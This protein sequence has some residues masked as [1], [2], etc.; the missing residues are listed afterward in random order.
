MIKSVVMWLHILVVSLLMCVYRTVGSCFCCS[1][2]MELLDIYLNCLKAK[3]IKEARRR[4]RKREE[5][6]ERN[7]KGNR[8]KGMNLLN[9]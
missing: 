7:G 4:R 8:E 1:P 5:A 2:A 6:N 9:G 3:K